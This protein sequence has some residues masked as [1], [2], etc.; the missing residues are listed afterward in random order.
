MF[1]KI[2]LLQNIRFLALQKGVKIGELESEAGVSVGYISRMLKVEDSGS[3]SLMDLAILASDKFGV[4]LNALAQ[5]DLSEMLPNEL[6]LAKFFSRLEKKT[7]E[8]FFAW[9]YE[10]KQMLLAS[11]SEPKPQIFIN[12]FSDNYEI[13]FRSGFNSENNLGDGAAYVQIGRRIL[14]VFQIL[15]FEET[16]RESKCGYEFYFVDDVSEGMVSPILC[17]YEDNRLFKISDKLFKCALETSHQIKITQQTR[18]TIDSFM[19]E[20]EEDDLPF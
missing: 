19:S 1:D 15:H 7:T 13:Y 11:T 17:V 12:S 6:Y 9:T 4:S 3:A 8:G 18:E 20:T 2:K 10:P 16:S 5:T 14:Y